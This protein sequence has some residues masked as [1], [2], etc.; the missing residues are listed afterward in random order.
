MKYFHLALPPDLPLVRTIFLISLKCL[1][2]FSLIYECFSFAFRLFLFKIFIAFGF[3]WFVRVCVCFFSS[4]NSSNCASSSCACGQTGNHSDSGLIDNQ[5]I[6]KF[7]TTPHENVRSKN[8]SIASANEHLSYATRIKTTEP[9]YVNRM[10]NLSVNYNNIANNIN[11]SD[12]Y[13]V[14]V[15]HNDD[16]TKAASIINA[17]RVKS[18]Y[19]LMGKPPSGERYL[20][21]FYGLSLDEREMPITRERSKLFQAINT[22]RCVGDTKKN[23]KLAGSPKLLRASTCDAYTSRGRNRY[24]HHKYIYKQNETE[25]GKNHPRN[26]RFSSDNN[27]FTIFCLNDIKLIIFQFI[28]LSLQINCFSLNC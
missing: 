5:K 18:N 27:I 11:E 15:V 9:I 28:L 4:Q 20:R 21:S 14:V 16:V 7:R 22:K 10:Q 13:D 3:Y 6:P 17:S 26:L 8:D 12:Y 24:V 2:Y 19:K 23:P 1:C 25:E